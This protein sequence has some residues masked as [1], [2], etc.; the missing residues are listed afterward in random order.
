MT[1]ELDE[2]T[3]AVAGAVLFCDYVPNGKYTVEWGATGYDPYDLP[4][5]DDSKTSKG[6]IVIK[7][8]PQSDLP[9]DAV[10]ACTNDAGTMVY[11]SGAHRAQT[12]KYGINPLVMMKARPN[13]RRGHRKCS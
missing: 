7:W 4:E 6:E 3:D 9:L 10:F 2:F 11:Q 8:M 12:D 5:L 1:D 13:T